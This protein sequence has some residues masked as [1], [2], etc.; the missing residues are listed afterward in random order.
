MYQKD[1]LQSWLG[2]GPVSWVWFGHGV[3]D[4]QE[5]RR[6]TVHTFSLTACLDVSIVSEY[7]YYTG[8]V[9]ICYCTL[10]Y[11]HNKQEAF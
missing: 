1:L 8:V 5:A 7:N 4:G 3:Q 2:L 6:R 9:G 11:S 10:V